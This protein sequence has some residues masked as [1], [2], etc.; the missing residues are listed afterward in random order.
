MLRKLLI[1]TTILFFEITSYANA[2]NLQSL[3]NKAKE[4]SVVNLQKKVYKGGIV[5]NKTITLNCNGATIDALGKKDVV[6]IKMA[7]NVVLRNCILVNSGSSGWRMDA[8]IK[9]VGA[10]KAK[11]LN[12]KI[13]NCLYGIV[14]KNARGILIK[15]NKISSKPYSEGVKGDA[16]RL[17][18]SG[19]SKVVG[20]YIHDS[21]DVVSIFSNNVVFDSNKV[22]NSHIGTMIQ[23]SKGNK[24][25]NCESL[26]NEVGILL[27]SAEDTDIEKFVVKDSKK[28]RGI[29]LV[30]AS[31]THIRNGKIENCRKGV[32][33]N[34]SPAKSGTKNYIDNVKFINN[35]IG[36]YLHTTAKQ[37]SRN[38][39]ENVK[40]FNNKTN[41]MDEWKTHE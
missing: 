31:N 12:N 25:I 10:K 13:K 23:N 18:W 38:V 34:L 30:R 36:I 26:N 27:N 6:V 21:R 15:N 29:V 9:L 37:R 17:W 41:L 14:A 28:Y 16:I 3:I 7:N 4:G 35:L 32:V 33:F 39:I 1:A 5:I 19:N 2:E 24:I 22:V 20:N 8:G 40:Y 11:I